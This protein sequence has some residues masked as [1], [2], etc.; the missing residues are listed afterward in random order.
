MTKK[1]RLTSL[2]N[3]GL[4]FVDKNLTSDNNKFIAWKKS[5]IRFIE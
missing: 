3:E 2:L 1:E 5:L 4:E